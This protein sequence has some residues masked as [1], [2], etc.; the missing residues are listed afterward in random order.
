MTETGEPIAYSALAKGVP[1]L[2]QSG[3]EFGRVEHVLQI[4]EEDVFDGIV[5][6]TAHG[7]RFVDRD[8]VTEITTARVRCAL[9]DDQA[10]DLPAPSGS[11]VYVADGEQD[12]GPS[13][14]DRFGRM[15]GRAHW[16]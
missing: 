4:P 16:A 5:V 3:H 9:T 13:L 1:L 10:A 8:Q 6:S 7:L 11:P 2:T 14:H 12:T 15:F